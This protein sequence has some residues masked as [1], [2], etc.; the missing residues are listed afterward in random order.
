MLIVRIH[1]NFDN[2]ERQRKTIYNFI[3]LFFHFYFVVVAVVVKVK[4]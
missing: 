3:V 2:V 4:R 1:V